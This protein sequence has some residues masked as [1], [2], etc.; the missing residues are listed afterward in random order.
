MTH[1]FSKAQVIKNWQC[2]HWA[3]FNPKSS[4]KWPKSAISTKKTNEAFLDLISRQFCV[5]VIGWTFLTK[6]EYFMTNMHKI[7]QNKSKNSQKWA[8]WLM[9]VLF[10]PISTP[11]RLVLIFFWRVII[12]IHYSKSENWSVNKKEEPYIYYLITEVKPQKFHA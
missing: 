10:V 9:M 11:F 2:Y 12:S 8:K 1:V 4:K 5:Q 7:L 3:N 6:F